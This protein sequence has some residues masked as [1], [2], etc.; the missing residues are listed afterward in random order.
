MLGAH[1]ILLCVCVCVYIMAPFNS[2]VE[3]KQSFLCIQYDEIFEMSLHL[4]QPFL[5]F[6]NLVSSKTVEYLL[7]ETLHHMQ[8]NHMSLNSL[9]FFTSRCKSKC[10]R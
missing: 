7:V 1:D 3:Y 6:S 2:K 5:N 10:Q 9:C 4:F 8:Q